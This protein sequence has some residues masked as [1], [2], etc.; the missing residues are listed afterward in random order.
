MG[1]GT[2][3]AAFAAAVEWPALPERLRVKA[4]E[5][6]LDILGVMFAGV[7]AEEC[8]AARRA[9]RAWGRGDEASVAGIADKY[10]APTAAFLNALHGRI[11][12]FDDTYEPGIV[13]PGS[14]VIAAALAL[15]E[16]HAV[17]GQHF[18]S[19]VIAG[20]E[21]SNRVAAA[22]NPSHYAS[23]FHSTGTCNVFGATAAAARILG[24]DATATAEALGLAGAA[25][26][27]LRQ[28]QFD[29]SILDSAFHGARAAQS[30]V[31]AAQL[32][33]EGVGG[34]PG[35]LDGPMG[36]CAVMAPQHDITRLDAELGSRYEFM[37]TTIKPYP[38]CRFTHGP[39]ET[40]LELKRA[41]AIDPQQ[42]QSI[43]VDTFKQSMELSDRAQIHTPSDAI[44]SHQYGVAM[45]L[46]QGKVVLASFAAAPLGEASIL[47]LAAK[48]R[49]RHDTEL[50][51]LFP[52]MWPHRVTV[53]LRDGRELSALSEYPP[54]RIAEI[55]QSAVDEK[56]LQNA[57]PYLGTSGVRAVQ[58]LVR[59][60][61][62]CR[63][64]RELTEILRA[65]G[66]DHA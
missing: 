6:V 65:R 22:V 5:H 56:F 36:F 34:P 42:V 66:A 3:L 26:A 54:G 49:V 24:L 37:Q 12:T 9:A 20:Y 52:R 39:I 40:M 29:G 2:N 28:H 32:R 1:A 63:D 35:I 62:D 23:G 8:A 33:R 45:A 46:A 60:L 38:T 19:A 16:K 10:P 53:K 50:E 25:A 48:V 31:M 11:H 41:H 59:A 51:K 30:G 47:Q 4:V 64:L 57:S 13:H 61:P 15:G 18:L 43:D 7:A 44:L 14:S 27:G 17:D 21:V 58:T 55:P